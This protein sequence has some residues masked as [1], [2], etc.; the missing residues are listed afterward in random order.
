MKAALNHDKKC[1]AGS[2]R[3]ETVQHVWMQ[4]EKVAIKVIKSAPSATKWIIS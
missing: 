2:L 1:R 4:M 3:R